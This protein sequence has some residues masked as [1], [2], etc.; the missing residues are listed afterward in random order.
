ME[1][2]RRRKIGR[3]VEDA[4][5]FGATVLVAFWAFGD[6]SPAWLTPIYV[7]AAFAVAVLARRLI[8][9]ARARRNDP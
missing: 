3:A 2:S 6:R 1:A 4:V 9:W 7:A 8:V 5:L